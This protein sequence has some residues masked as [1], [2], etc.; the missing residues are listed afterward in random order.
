MFAPGH[1]VESA[2]E[3]MSFDA[4]TLDRAAPS[5]P[6]RAKPRAALDDPMFFRR[7]IIPILMT[8]GVVLLFWGF[9]LITSGQYNALPDLLPAWSPYALFGAGAVFL[10]LAIINILS[11]KRPG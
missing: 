7:T 4:S 1:A 10:V 3:Q 5:V 8:F 11:M 6:S 2:D 9:L